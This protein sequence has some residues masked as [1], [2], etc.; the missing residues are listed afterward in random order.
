MDYF[1]HIDTAGLPDLYEGETPVE[2]YGYY[3]EMISS[4]AVDYIRSATAT[5]SPSIFRSTTRLR[6]GRGRDRRTMPQARR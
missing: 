3:T 4:R 5:T 6:T 1:S 2:E